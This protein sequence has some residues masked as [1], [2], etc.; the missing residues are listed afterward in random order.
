MKV[1]EVAP[2]SRRIVYVEENGGFTV[3]VLGQV[4]ITLIVF[5]MV[6]PVVFYVAVNL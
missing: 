4:T 5:S 3:T 1:E 6:I 2:T